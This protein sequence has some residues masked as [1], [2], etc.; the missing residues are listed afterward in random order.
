VAAEDLWRMFP[1]FREVALEAA[2]GGPIDV[3]GHHLPYVGRLD[4]GDVHYAHGYTGN[5]VGPSHLVGELLAGRVLGAP[6]PALEELP[7]ATME[8]MRFPP[9]PIRSPGAL[10]AN[11]AIRHKDEAEE[12]GEEPNPIVD[13]VARLPR[14]LGYNLGP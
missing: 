1:S 6:D 9:E 10:I 11:T 12:R 2:W 3:A 14:R 8:P 7:I 4:T 13:F 5:G